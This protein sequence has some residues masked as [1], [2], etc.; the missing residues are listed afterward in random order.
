MEGK[1]LA[2]TVNLFCNGEA[3]DRKEITLAPGESKDVIFTSIPQQTVSMTATLT[4]EDVLSADDRAFDGAFLQSKKKVLLVTEQNIFL[5]K[6]Y[7]LLPEVELYKTDTDN[8]E[9]LSGY[10]LYIFDGVLP[11]ALPDDGFLL[12]WNPPKTIT[13]FL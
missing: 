8:I 6:V 12:L 9:Q 4:P 11:E 5:E 1:Q 2:K 3:F 7:S 10:S 13:Y